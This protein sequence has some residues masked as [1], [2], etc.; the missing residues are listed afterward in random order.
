V[1]L[2]LPHIQAQDCCL[3]LQSQLASQAALLSSAKKHSGCPQPGCTSKMSPS[4]ALAAH[5]V[6][7]L[8]ARTAGH[9]GSEAWLARSRACWARR[10]DSGD[11]DAGL[12]PPTALTPRSPSPPQRVPPAHIP[13][14]AGRAPGLLR[15]TTCPSLS[16]PHA[17][18]STACISQHAQHAPGLHGLALSVGG[19]DDAQVV[20]NGLALGGQVVPAGWIWGNADVR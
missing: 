5:L 2:Q 8:A 20:N 13:H 10:V 4:G 3:H 19:S 15:P 12:L 14:H 18:Q 6:K 16:A 1:T 17:I 9:E 7:E 11:V